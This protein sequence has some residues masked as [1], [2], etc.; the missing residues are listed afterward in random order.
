MSGGG[1]M[2]ENWLLF[3][4]FCKMMVVVISGLL[5][6]VG[7]QVN[8]AFRRFLMPIF[9]MSACV[10]IS[11]WKG[12]EFNWIM[13]ISLPLFIGTLHL[14]YSNNEG[15][16]WIKRLKIAALLSLSFLPFAFVFGRWEVYIAH[17]I[18]CFLGMGYFG[19][20]NPFDEAV[21]E[22]S[23]IGTMAVFLPIMMI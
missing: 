11:F 7:G 4:W 13:L 19:I 23:L 8:K 2:S 1:Y 6:R 22:E 17:C 18:L 16:G 9:Y 14:G 12:Y 5:Y 10:G 20:T 3:V 21:T 15:K